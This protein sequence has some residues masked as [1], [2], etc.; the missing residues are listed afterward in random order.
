MGG[1]TSKQGTGGEAGFTLVELLVVMLVIGILAA[2]AIPTFFNQ[3]DKAKDSQA[4]Q[5]AGTAHTAM[6]VLARTRGGD[7]TGI[8]ADDLIAEEEALTNVAISEPVVTSNS[9]TVLVS[10]S[11]GNTYSISRAASGALDFDCGVHGQG[12]CPE[13]GNWGN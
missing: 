2:I 13:D 7:Y 8:T 5:A 12:G 3:T 6:E 4:K 11:T 10:S 1:S 9:F